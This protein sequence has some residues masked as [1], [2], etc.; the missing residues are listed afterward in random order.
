MAF[1]MN[2][3]QLMGN[4]TKDPVMRSTQSGDKVA[5]FSVAVTEKWKDNNGEW[6]EQTDF[7]NC[8]AWKHFAE[9]AGKLTKGTKVFVQ[10]KFK[11]RKWQK[12]G[13]DQ[14]STEV[15]VQ[16]MDGM[17]EGIQKL[18][19]G[20]AASSDRGGYDAPAQSAPKSNGAGFQK[21][22]DDEIPF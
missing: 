4:L 10:G 2:R 6:K 14:Y 15:V 13:V 1:V 21:T 11:T 18:G 12:D 3:V 7:V 17:L 20:A 22:L 16:G 19:G 8:V 5:S 9:T